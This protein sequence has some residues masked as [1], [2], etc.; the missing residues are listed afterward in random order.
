MHVKKEFNEIDPLRVGKERQLCC[1][2]MFRLTWGL[3]KLVGNTG[4]VLLCCSRRGRDLEYVVWHLDS[5][6]VAENENMHGY[7][8]LMKVRRFWTISLKRYVT[9][10]CLA[11]AC[12]AQMTKMESAVHIHVGHSLFSDRQPSNAHGCGRRAIKGRPNNCGLLC[13]TELASMEQLPVFLPVILNHRH[14]ILQGAYP[15]FSYSHGVFFCNR[16]RHYA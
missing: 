6:L 1:R 13:A 10:R 15:T 9:H 5:F 11:A 8:Q 14:R 12:I 3:G 16:S 2:L 4:L 7:V